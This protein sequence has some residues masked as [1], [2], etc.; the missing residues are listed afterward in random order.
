VRPAPAT[1]A[2]ALLAACSSTVAPAPA[3]PDP[4]AGGAGC[5][6]ASRYPG[7]VGIQ[8]DPAV[9]LREDFEEPTLDDLV[10]RWEDVS[11]RAAMSFD[12]DR[13]PASAGAR[14]LRLAGGGHL[15]RRLAPGR[16]RVHLRFYARFDEACS[17]V[18]HF[19]HLGGYNPTTPWPQGG[20]GERPAG[21]ERFTVGIEPM[22]AAW[23]WDFYAYW[24]RMRSNPGGR[25]WGND[26][27]G[28]PSPAPAARGRWMAVELMVK[29]NDP[30][31]AS[32]GEVAF[33]IDGVRQNHLGPGFPRGEWVWDSFAPNPAC[34]PLAPC[35]PGGSASRCCQD[36]EG[37]RFRTVPEL[38]VNF[39]WLLHYVD[40]DPSCGVRLDDVVVATE[41]IGPIAPR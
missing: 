18:H 27:S 35:D 23:G 37:F 14:S 5:G 20:A 34:T 41:Y 17:G 28:S 24:M 30:V 36:F 1:L 9:I 39:V 33:W 25:Y 12:A 15:Y 10:A 2:A 32:N 7:D 6:I 3:P 4:C 19:V 26:F 29:A 31:D 13:P 11:G 22:G 8:G 21:N 38:N 40:S 16:D